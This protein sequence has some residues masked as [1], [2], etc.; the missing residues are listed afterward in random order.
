MAKTIAAV[1]FSKCKPEKCAPDG[2]C[3][4]RKTCKLKVLLQDEPGFPPMILGPCKGCGDCIA[5][6]PFEAIRLM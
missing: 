1:V 3:P 2:R 4:A 5:A 6:C